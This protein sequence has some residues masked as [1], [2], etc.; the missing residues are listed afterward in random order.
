MEHTDYPA[1]KAAAR[2]QRK[3]R[4]EA[5]PSELTAAALALFVEKGFAATRLDDVAS[6]AGV[7]KGTLY[8]YFDSK[9]DLFKAV[10]AEGIVPRIAEAVQY[11]GGFEGTCV[12]LLRQLIENW[13]AQIGSTPLAGVA[14]LIISE[15]RNFPEVARYYQE[16]V[17]L[18]IRALLRTVL[19]RGMAAGEFREMDAEAVI[20][21]IISPLLAL[22][23]SRFSIGLCSRMD[24]PE[25]LLQVH[26]DMLMQGLQRPVSKP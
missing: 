25:T 26:V 23:L 16:S 1:A 21:V 6:H 19:E 3:R 15:S 9:E 20:D 24:D 14:K 12:A 2:P 22:V 11:I 7:S 13:W 10:I 8:L 17:I 4:K 18:P 5:R